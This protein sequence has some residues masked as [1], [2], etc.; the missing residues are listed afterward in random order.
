MNA[1]GQYMNEAELSRV[2]LGKRLLGLDCE[3]LTAEREE[4]EKGRE[5]KRRKGE[6]DCMQLQCYSK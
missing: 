1:F 6:V 2:E 5:E 3:L 4:R